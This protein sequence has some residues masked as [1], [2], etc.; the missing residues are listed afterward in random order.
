[1]EERFLLDGIALYAAHVTPW[2]IER[3]TLVVTYFA[4]SGLTI[5]NGTA[6]AA[7]ETTYPVAIKLL[8]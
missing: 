5:G 8:V 1:M 2:N 4:D 7:S 3:A 6:V